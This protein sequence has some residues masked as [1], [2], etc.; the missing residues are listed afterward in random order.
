MALKALEDYRLGDKLWRLSL[1]AILGFGWMFLTPAYSDDPLQIAASQISQLESDVQ[2][3]TDQAKTQELIDLAKSK[4]SAAVAA[5]QNMQDAQT[6]YDTAVSDGA[7]ATTA[8][9]NAQSA[10][11]SQQTVRDSAY[12]NLQNKQDALDIANINLSN[13]PVP[14]SGSQGVSFRIYPLSRS[15]NIAYLSQYAGLMCQGA[16]PYFYT[17]AGDGAICGSSQNIIG[18]FNATLTIPEEINDVYFAGYTDD[19]FKLYVDG[20]LEISN[21]IEQGGTWSQYSRHFNTSTDKTLELEVWWYNGGGPGIMT[22][23]WG[24][25]GIWTGVPGAYLSYGQGSSQEVIDAYNQAV[26]AQQTAQTN[27]NNAL[28]TYNT[29]NDLLIQYNQN[30]T[31]AEQNLTTAN[32]NLT[33]AQQNLTNATNNYNTAI[34]EMQVAIIDAQTEYNKQWD[35]EEKQRVAAA[36]AQALAN[37][38]QPTPEPTIIIDP[39]PEPTVEPVA[40]TPTPEQTKPTDPTPEPTPETTH[41]VD[42]T[43][44]PT[45]EP[46]VEPSPE[47]SPQ[48]TDINP[49]LTPEPTQDPVVIPDKTDNS[50]VS[51]QMANLI[52]DITNSNTLTKLTPE[53][54][55]AVAGTLGIKTEEL[56]KV[57]ELAKADPNVGQALQ[58]FGDRANANLNAPMPY[59]LADATTEVAAEKLLSDPIGALT[60]IDLTQ[61]LSPSEWGKDMTDD[62]REKAQ[63]VIV[64]VIIASNL[65]AAAM[66]RRIK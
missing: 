18:I 66:T 57:A 12:T 53:Q 55:I 32:E 38:P 23:G 65:V 58:E 43:P 14:S 52:A 50:P 33:N 5:K 16:L 27:Y 47:P 20:V 41:S 51:P 7:T 2:K 15:G 17:Y 45:P 42:P 4:Y 40:P 3:L 34:T 63:E 28:S 13:T 49:S 54:K 60:N 36:I 37:Q 24:Y 29:E 26:L 9:N 39:T 30:L 48:P 6:A 19:G 11:D 21:W 44:D 61:V 10:V 59:T 8:K 46:S 64:P 31:T 56:A 35:F 62:Q 1:T 25:N 22:I